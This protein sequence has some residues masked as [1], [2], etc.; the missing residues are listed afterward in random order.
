[1]GPATEEAYDELRRRQ[2]LEVRP[3]GALAARAVRP[4]DPCQMND[5]KLRLAGGV[6]ERG[7]HVVAHTAPAEDVR[8]RG[9]QGVILGQLAAQLPLERTVRGNR[10]PRRAPLESDVALSHS[11]RQAVARSFHPLARSRTLAC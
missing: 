9:A 7:H 4:A 6:D 1:M 10:L 3:C 8:R 2:A 11:A 5:R